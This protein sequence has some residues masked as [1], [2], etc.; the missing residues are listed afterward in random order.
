MEF[1]AEINV[2]LPSWLLSPKVGPIG[3]SQ[4]IMSKFQSNQEVKVAGHLLPLPWP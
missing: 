4:T 2:S 3:L 1:D